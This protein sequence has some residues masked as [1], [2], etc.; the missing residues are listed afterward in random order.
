MDLF[1][2]W[3]DRKHNDPAYIEKKKKKEEKKKQEKMEYELWLKHENAHRL[4]SS[5]TRTS[6]SRTSTSL[7]TSS[8][9]SSRGH[10]ME[11]LRNRLQR[12]R[13]L[14]AEQMEAAA[15]LNSSRRS[16]NEPIH[17][18]EDMMRQVRQMERL[19]LR[20]IEQL[21]QLNRLPEIDTI[22]II[23]SDLPDDI[24]DSLP[25]RLRSLSSLE[26]MD[27]ETL[28][29]L[30]P[31]VNR[32]A[33][34]DQI[35]QVPSRIYTKSQQN[36]STPSESTPQCAICFSEFEEGEAVKTLPKCLHGFHTECIDK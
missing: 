17:E 34:R 14:L 33:T 8:S 29:E 20:Q 4:T 35:Q 12:S 3:R 16:F 22:E 5:T 32:G 9:S 2:K 36:N 1:R 18:V 19:I 26:G 15:W 25:S 7:S 21:R 23:I 13:D 31:P 6:P 10:T 27:Y 28:L 30:L 11:S 24:G